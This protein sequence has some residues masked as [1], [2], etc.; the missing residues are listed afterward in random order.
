[1][2]TLFEKCATCGNKTTGVLF[3]SDKC[4]LA[5]SLAQSVTPRGGSK[6]NSPTSTTIHLDPVGN[7][8]ESLTTDEPTSSAKSLGGELTQYEDFFAGRSGQRKTS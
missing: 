2:S 6:N 4:R 3:C 5:A 1:M 8:L 7:D